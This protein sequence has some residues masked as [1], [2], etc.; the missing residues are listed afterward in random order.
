[1]YMYVCIYIYVQRE[2]ERDAHIVSHMFVLHTWY[3]EH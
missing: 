3:N 1:M 2:R